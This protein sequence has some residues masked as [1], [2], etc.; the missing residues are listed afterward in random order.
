[1][2]PD[3]I[4]ESA[5]RAVQLLTGSG[6]TVAMAESLT[7]G[8]VV[9]A[10]VGV[11]GASKVVRGGVVAYMTDLKASLLGV[12]EDLLGRV[13]AV[14]PDVAV[15]MARGAAVRL[16]ADYGLATTGVAGPDPQD[17]HPV[18][19][20]WIALWD[21]TA[22]EGRGGVATTRGLHLDPSLGRAG[23]RTATVAE[24]LDHLVAT[25]TA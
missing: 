1:M 9:A 24:A 3:P 13:G 19:E 2:T 23:I 15:A 22:G 10:L 4:E 6:R 11:P 17:G 16:G 5:T 8:L 12:D 14:D 7:G 20:V 21:A 25:L 18:G